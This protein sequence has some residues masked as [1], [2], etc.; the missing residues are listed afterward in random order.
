MI[1]SGGLRTVHTQGVQNHMAANA[2]VQEQV[3]LPISVAMEVVMQGIKIRLG[4]SVVTLTGVVCGIAFLMSILTGQIIKKGVAA[5]DAVR[6]EVDRMRSFM[7]ADLPSL[8]GKTVSLLLA[9]P[10]S[11]AEMRLLEG[12]AGAQTTFEAQ[13]G[14]GK[15]LKR[16]LAGVREVAPEAFASG[17]VL[18][19]ML[20]HGALPK[21]DLPALM[22]RG[23]PKSLATT[24]AAK[25]LPELNHERLTLLSREFT[26]EEIAKRDAKSGQERFRNIWIGI[27]SLLVTV[28]G[29]ANAMLMSVT[30][31]FR[32]IGTMKCLGA[33]SSFIRRVF[34]LESAILGLSGGLSG[35]VFGA[36]FSLVAY[37]A[38]YGTEMV[39]SAASFAPIAGY[40]VVSTLAGV[41]L[42]M[43]AA[44]YPAQ[45]A[46]RMVPAMA[47]R[48]NV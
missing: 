13:A 5:E 33:L 43:V 45:V 12:L 15:L 39:W 26:P 28:I 2:T 32:E 3:K 11:E 14:A 41:I 19:L 38:T 42:S 27:I 29:I 16:P 35:A 25:A 48:S 24:F 36:L 8:D 18:V 9:G 47:L 37:M 34:L 40:G 22:D 17:S 10:V 21:A 30:E 46:A 23:E 20:G 7:R 6:E 44:V 31:R 1:A 4:R